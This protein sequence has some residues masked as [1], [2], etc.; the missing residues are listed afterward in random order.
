MIA[1]DYNSNNECEQSP[2]VPIL[3]RSMQ[4]SPS[5]RLAT[6]LQYT[7]QNP[8][9]DQEADADDHIYK[10]V[11]D[12]TSQKPG[13]IGNE[14]VHEAHDDQTT[15]DAADDACDRVLVAMLFG[16]AGALFRRLQPCHIAK[17][18]R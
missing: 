1:L 16:H 13:R 18:T 6:R 12:E 10:H 4:W 3:Q 8:P 17:K 14:K 7:K 9:K 2:I 5:A 11:P 15:N